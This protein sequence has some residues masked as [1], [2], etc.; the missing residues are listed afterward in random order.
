MLGVV[1]SNLTSWANNT[2]HA[3]IHR[4]TVAKR[5]QHVAPNNVAICCA[6]MLR[7]F[8][9]GLKMPK[10]L[11][12]FSSSYLYKACAPRHVHA[13]SSYHTSTESQV[14][15]DI[16]GWTFYRLAPCALLSFKST[17]LWTSKSA[18]SCV[19]KSWAAPHVF[20][21]PCV[22]MTRWLKTVSSTFQDLEFDGSL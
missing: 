20:K 10:E 12:S 16:S 17:N 1:A 11:V 4:N 14:W 15:A 7:S 13:L 5:T 6:G 22:H 3:A 8:G 2:Q 21:N 19:K 9:Q 18:F